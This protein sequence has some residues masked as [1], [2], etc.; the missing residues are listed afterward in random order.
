MNLAYYHVKAD[1]ESVPSSADADR[2]SNIGRLT[3]NNPPRRPPPPPPASSAAPLQLSTG[4]IVSFPISSPRNIVGSTPAD[5]AAHPAGNHG[6]DVPLRPG[7]APPLPPKPSFARAAPVQQRHSVNQQRISAPPLPPKPAAVR[8]PRFSDQAPARPTRPVPPPPPVARDNIA[9]AKFPH[10]SPSRSK[11]GATK[12]NAKDRGPSVSTR[13]DAISPTTSSTSVQAPPIIR[14]LYDY[15]TMPVPFPAPACV[16]RESGFTRL[17]SRGRTESRDFHGLPYTASALS[18]AGA[19]IP[20]CT[21]FD[22]RNGAGAIAA[23]RQLAKNSAMSFQGWNSV[24]NECIIHCKCYVGMKIPQLCNSIVDQFVAG[25]SVGSRQWRAAL[26]MLVGIIVRGSIDNAEAGTALLNDVVRRMRAG[27]AVLR[28]AV[29]TL[30]VNIGAHAGFA[31][32]YW[33]VVERMV[34]TV[35]S[36]VVEAMEAES[37]ECWSNESNLVGN[38]GATENYPH[39]RIDTPDTWEKAVKCFL[40]LVSGGIRFGN[41]ATVERVKNAGNAFGRDLR[42]YPVISLQA[43]IALGKHI[44]PTTHPIVERVLVGDCLWRCFRGRFEEDD[45]VV[46]IQVDE[47]E[48]Y[49]AHGGVPAI[50]EV[51]IRVR[52]LTARRRL[53]ALILEVAISR[54]HRRMRDSNTANLK[55]TCNFEQQA[56]WLYGL[57]R[58]NDAGDAMV[59]V[60]RVGPEPTFVMD[61]LRHLLFEPIA[62]NSYGALILKSAVSSNSSRVDERLRSSVFVFDST[63]GGQKSVEARTVAAASDHRTGVIAANRALHKLFVTSVLMELENMA[64]AFQNRSR[65]WVGLTPNSLIAEI[66]DKVKILRAD[67]LSSALRSTKQVWQ[68]LYAPVSNLAN[69]SCSENEIV[70]AIDAV[71]SVVLLPVAYRNILIESADSEAEALLAGERRVLGHGACIEGVKMLVQLLHLSNFESGCRMLSE[72]RQ[73][74]VEL[75]GFIQDQGQLVRQFAE[76]SDAIVAHRASSIANAT[77]AS[78]VDTRQSLM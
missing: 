18:A 60:F 12:H 8:A 72:Q 40:A 1:T 9:G 27:P 16:L 62:A 61:T 5:I 75:L 7:A 56:N 47:D 33:R 51:Y 13:E 39:E 77:S 57:L 48:L 67:G 31:A 30:L 21:T 14:Q 42:P 37:R 71:L 35:F 66:E 36:D 11:S 26:E 74:L 58:A 22:A 3:P 23:K 52:S 70:L 38:R 49:A 78:S 50:I 73:C 28:G 46:R 2:P 65:A 10:A 69:H 41:L 34:L 29:F 64:L 76:D 19:T 63:M 24:T 25:H 54:V 15:P 32:T 17:F 68:T 45:D 6:N 43:L 20:R 44:S 59:A 55:E 53:F 4:P